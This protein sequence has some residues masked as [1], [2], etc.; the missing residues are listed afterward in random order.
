MR[1]IRDPRQT[2]MFDPFEGVL[3]GMARERILSGWRGLFR[4]NLPTFLVHCGVAT[5][6][7]EEFIEA[8]PEGEPAGV[9]VAFAHQEATEAGEV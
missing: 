9:T 4:L 3:S 5:D 6:G 8:A 2:R 1:L 7:E